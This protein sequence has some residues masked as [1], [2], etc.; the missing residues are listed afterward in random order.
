MGELNLDSLMTL[1][2]ILTFGGLYPPLPSP[3]KRFLVLSILQIH[4]NLDV[5]LLSN[6]RDQELVALTDTPEFTFVT[7]ISQDSKSVI[8]AE[9]KGR[10]ERI[11]LYQ[12]YLDEPKIMHPL[13]EV[14]PN[15]FMRGGYFSPSGDTL[16]YSVNYDFD[17]NTETENFRVIVQD[18]STGVK[19]EVARAEKPNYMVL[20]ISSDGE[21]ILYSRMDEEPGGWQWWLVKPDGSDNREV[22]NF[23]SKAKVFADWTY[24][25]LILFSTDTYEGMMWDSV[26]VGKYNPRTDRIDWLA[27]P[28]DELKF[29]RAFVPKE[30]QHVVM[31][32]ERDARSKPYIYDLKTSTMVKTTPTRGNL[33]PITP[34]EKGEWLGIFYSSLNPSEIVRFNIQMAEPDHFTFLTNLLGKSGICSKDLTPAEDFQWVSV[35]GTLI[36]GWLYKSKRFNGKTIV[37]IHGGPTAHSEDAINNQIQYFCS[38]GFNVLDPNYRGS[39]GY[40]VDFREL[41]KADG[42][43]SKEQ[44]DIRTGIQALI[45][46]KVS[47]PNKVGI[48]GTSFGGY[49][50]WWAITN[51]PPNIVAASAPICG[52]TDLVLDYETTRPDLKPYSEEMMGGS[53]MEVP[54]RYYERSPI[55]FIQNI[56]GRVLIVQGLKDPNVTPANVSEVEKRLKENRI[57]YEK[58]VFDDEG[59]GIVKAKN[60]KALYKRLSKF[61]NQ[62]L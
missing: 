44:E 24:D 30:S 38:A 53:P 40:G 6:G 8:V 60:R 27:K 61:F 21:N 4:S 57:E 19:E 25:G 51:F 56:K 29:D 11:T 45:D 46:Q 35:D 50:S 48:T 34:V 59:H 32:Q 20:A 52:M 10:N 14:E 43:G 9:D 15:Y 36:H 23:G 39:T 2:Q 54:E 1:P 62:A 18:L 37:Y 22:I 5:F 41:I 26:G 28:D 17:S 12:V 49:S 3:D 13:T 58:L 31:T 7:D 33:I 55:N 42:W 16:I 47:N